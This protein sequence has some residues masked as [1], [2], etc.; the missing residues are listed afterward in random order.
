MTHPRTRTGRSL[1]GL[2]LVLMGLSAYGCGDT[3]TQSQPAELGGLSVSEG[4]LDPQFNPATTSYVVQLPTDVSSTTITVAPRVAGDTIRIDNQQTTS[5]TVTLTSQ[6]AEQSVNIVV[7]DTG[8]GGTSKSYTI[9]VRR[10]SL[11][12]DN[13][14]NNLT[15]SPGTLAPPFDKG[16]RRYSVSVENNIGSITITPT[17]SDPAATMTVN[18]QSTNSGQSRTIN[19]GSGGQVTTLTVTVT[20]QNGSTQSYEVAVSRGPSN[21]NNL[22]GLAISSGTLDPVFRADRTAYIVNV[23]SS[24][25]SV[26]IRPTLADSTA[27]LTVNGQAVT[28]GQQSQPIGLNPPGGSPTIVTIIVISQKGEPKPYSVTFNPP[29]LNGNSNLSGLTVSQ[30]TF[31]SPFNANDLS[32]TVNVGSGVGSV[33]VRP[34]L[35]TT[36]ATMTVNGEAVTSG[37]QSAP[38]LLNPAGG[39]PTSIPIVVTAQN[40]T[41]TKTYTVTVVRAALNGNNDLSA[42]IVSPGTLDSPFDKDDQSY[43]VNVGSGVE[44]MRVRPTLAGT[45]ATVTVSGQAVTSGQLSAPIPLNPAGGLPTSIPIVVTAQNQTTKLYSVIVVRAA[46]GG[47]SNLQRLIISPGT[48]TQPFT[49]SRQNYTVNLTSSTVAQVAVT[50]TLQDTAASMSINGQGTSSGLA[51]T[52]DLKPA[53]ESTE[54]E[55]TVT[56][57]NSDQRIYTITVNRPAPSSNNNLSAFSITQGTLTPVFAA[58]TLGY[59]VTIDSAV[60]SVA[61]SATK[62]D[63]NATMAIGSVTVPPGTASG[64]STFTL[65]GAGGEPTPISVTVTAQN[66]VD[67]KTYTISVIRP[68]APTPPAKPATAPDLLTA[69]DSCPL[70]VLD[71]DGDT[72]TNECFGS[73]SNEDNITTIKKPGFSVPTPGSGETAKLYMNGSEVPSSITENGAT[74]ILRPNADLPDGPYAVTYTLSNSVGESDKS[75]AMTPQLE[76]NTIINN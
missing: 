10:T 41:T 57:P 76:I 24:V 27:T 45:T 2:V 68:A 34:T 70:D 18:G 50:A 53:G 73:T 11:A 25:T 37:Q 30:G 36:T 43:T 6:G 54:V 59:T 9:L 63:P 1:I 67:V 56:A 64:Q 65:N 72:I 15:V 74:I 22:G 20:A 8:T 51:R 17:L 28:S 58:N 46:L 12:G 52:I 5:Q 69:D 13:F 19:L 47:N 14:L 48:F 7:T 61:V 62:D 55:I 75:P 40:R 38:I 23:G 33:R 44:S 26:R 4:T 16:L 29:A 49:S 35:A 32:Y 21:N 71:E 3:G 60:G 66:G 39:L 42:L 31:D